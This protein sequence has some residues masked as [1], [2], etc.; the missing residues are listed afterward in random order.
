MRPTLPAPRPLPTAAL[1]A[2]ILRADARTQLILRLACDLGLRRAEIAKI[3]R[4]D[5]IDDLVGYSLRV[6]GKGERV[7]ILPLPTSL[8]RVILDAEGFL[9][10]GRDDGHLSARWVGKLAANAL[11]GAWSLHAGR[12]RFA[13]LAHRQC[14]DLLVVQDLLGHASPVTT[15]VYIAPDATKARTVIESLAA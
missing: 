11:P 2:A 12:H 4:D 13:T 5:V 10:P 3:H 14:G 1:D 15:R 7:R 8:A 9:F 6:R